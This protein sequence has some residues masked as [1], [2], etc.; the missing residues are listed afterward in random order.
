MHTVELL[1]LALAHAERMGFR[2]RQEWLNG[3]G[4]GAC[5][6]RGQKCL[7]LDVSL[8]ATEQLG[9]VL[10]ALRND[11]SLSLFPPPRVLQRWLDVRKVA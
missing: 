1:E 6:V 4:G 8:N 11:P 2:I 10:E 7:F 5:E 9:L 3:Y